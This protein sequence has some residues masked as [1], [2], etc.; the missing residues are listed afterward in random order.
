MLAP[1]VTGSGGTVV[2]VP[3]RT[4]P[5]AVVVVNRAGTHGHKVRIPALGRVFYFRWCLV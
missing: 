4:F 1:I 2:L 3:G 5:R